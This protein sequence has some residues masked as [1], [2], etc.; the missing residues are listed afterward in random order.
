MNTES[1]SVLTRDAA[2]Q[3]RSEIGE[4]LVWSID[5]DAPGNKVGGDNPIT[6]GPISQ[7]HVDIV[8]PVVEFEAMSFDHFSE[9]YLTPLMESMADALKNDGIR[10]THP[11]TLPSRPKMS[12][13]STV[14]D[15]LAIRGLIDET[16]IWSGG[17]PCQAFDIRFDVLYSRAQA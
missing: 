12:A 2:R 16:T 4:R 11:L 17:A 1:V 7:K 6:H 15:G 8:L 3:L 10:Y 5:I 9:K 14:Y 13:S